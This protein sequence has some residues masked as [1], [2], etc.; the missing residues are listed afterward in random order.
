MAQ[1]TGR[2]TK[3][4]SEQKIA[5]VDQFY[6]T[7]SDDSSSLLNS[8]GVYQRLSAY[9]KSLGH[10][11]EAH[12]FSRNA[13]VRKHI[14]QLIAQSASQESETTVV[15]AY[16]PLDIPALM[17]SSRAHIEQTLHQREDYFLKLHLRASRAIENYALIS[18]QSN[19][20]QAEMAT[21]KNKNTELQAQLSNLTNALI[22]A[23][24]DVAY[25]KR[26]IRN[27]VE[28]ERAQ[29]FMADLATQSDVVQ[30]VKPYVMSDIRT[31]MSDDKRTQQEAQ[32]EV[33]MLDLNNLFSL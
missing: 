4:T 24:K 13:D 17:M 16:E 6:I 22:A 2:P 32:A 29:L 21:A 19:K 14:E 7:Y 20:Y 1:R 3:A 30:K 31:F 11:L 9:A 27:N 28:P 12:D 26:V 33:D 5:I 23:Q 25:L 15:P 18:Q 8:H 10:P